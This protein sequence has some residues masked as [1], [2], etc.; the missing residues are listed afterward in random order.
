MSYALVKWIEEDRVSVI[1]TSWITKPALPIKKFPSAGAC[2]W[3]K[4]SSVY[5]TL[6]FDISGE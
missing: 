3:R 1:P 4:K 6:I 2:Y 5:D